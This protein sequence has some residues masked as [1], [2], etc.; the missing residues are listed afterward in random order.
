MPSAYLPLKNT[1]CPDSTDISR[2]LINPIRGLHIADVGQSQQTG[3]ISII[4]AEL[5]AVSVHF[6]A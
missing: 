5:I 2:I 1:D 3:N 4:H 6:K